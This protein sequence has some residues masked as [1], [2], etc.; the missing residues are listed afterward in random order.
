MTKQK[1]RVIWGMMLGVF[2]YWYFLLQ[3]KGML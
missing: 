2:I 3:Y 1:L